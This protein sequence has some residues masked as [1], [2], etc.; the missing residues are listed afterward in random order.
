MQAQLR[1]VGID[2]KV[3]VANS[4][5]IPAGHRDDTLELGLSSRNFSLV[6]DPLGTLLQDYGPKG[7]DWGAMN[8]SSPELVSVLQRLN[9]TVDPKKRA[10][11]QRRAAEI[12]HEELPVIPVS[13]AELAVVS[14]KRVAGVKVDPFETSYHIATMRWVQ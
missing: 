12:L 8:W 9:E 13:W 11:L 1:E 10:P 3:S 7:G 6:P 14:N 5:E 4:S 2:L